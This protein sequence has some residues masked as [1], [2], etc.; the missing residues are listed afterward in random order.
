MR[1]ALS[2]VLALTLIVGLSVPAQANTVSMNIVDGKTYN[3]VVHVKIDCDLPEFSVICDNDVTHATEFKLRANGKHVIMVR[4]P[5][6]KTWKKTITIKRK[7]ALLK[8]IKN[9]KTYKNSVKVKF[10]S[11]KVAVKLDDRRLLKSGDKITTKGWHTL[12]A[13]GPND[14]MEW[15]DIRVK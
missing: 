15:Y 5:N 3:K 12:I 1:K 14:T 4:T 11:D 2:I 9:L 10:N 7:N 13:Y 8:N 6:G